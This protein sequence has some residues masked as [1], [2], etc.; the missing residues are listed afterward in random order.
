[1]VAVTTQ[2]D[3]P[4]QV[5]EWSPSESR[6]VWVTEFGSSV[7][8]NQNDEKAITIEAHCVQDSTSNEFWDS[9]CIFH[10]PGFIWTWTHD[11]T[12]PYGVYA[13]KIIPVPAETPYRMKIRST[14]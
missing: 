4:G 5:S 14:L 10:A 12:N 8:F 6:F 11:N 13:E 1:L 3:A 7:S 9:K 2:A